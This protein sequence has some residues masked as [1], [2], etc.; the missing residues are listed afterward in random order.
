MAS[1]EKI[2]P[3]PPTAGL[4]AAEIRAAFAPFNWPVG[5]NNNGGNVG[6]GLDILHYCRE[7][8]VIAN[9][10]LSFECGYYGRVSRSRGIGDCSAGQGSGNFGG[11]VTRTDLPVIERKCF[12]PSEP[13][14]DN[15]WHK[16]ERLCEGW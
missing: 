10:S 14:S 8:K 5:G 11:G 1:R 16:V 3:P 13:L 7:C 12:V 9:G 2:S 6:R 15:E 4:S